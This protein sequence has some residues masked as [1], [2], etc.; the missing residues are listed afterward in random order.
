MELA[1]EDLFDELRE[2]YN[3]HPSK[4]KLRKQFEE[5]MWKSSETFHQYMH[6]KVILANQIPIPEDKVV[7]YIIDGIPQT[8]I[9][10]QA[11]IGQITTKASLLKVFEKVILKD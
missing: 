1:I 11:R 9:R 10:N 5:R 4:V 3:H 8:N 2:I 7:E 6:E